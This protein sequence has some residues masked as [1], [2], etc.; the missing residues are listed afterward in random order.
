MKQSFLV[1]I[2]LLASCARSPLKHVEDAMRS[3]SVPKNFQDS[4]SRESFFLTLKNHLEIIKKS[5][6][7]KDPMVFGKKSVEKNVYIESLEKLLQHDQ[8]PEWLNYIKD[9]FDFYEVYGKNE[10]GQVLTTGYY[11]PSARGSLVPTNE[12]SQALYAAPNDL[13]SIDLKKFGSRFYNGEKLELL[14]GRIENQTI[15]PYFSRK[16][17]DGDQKLKGKNLELV[18][19]DPIDAFFIQIQGSGWVLL[20]DGNKIHLGYANQ[21]GQPYFAIGKLIAKNADEMSKMSMQKIR[22]HLKNLPRNNQQDLFNKNPSYVFFKKLEGKALT[23]SGL[24]VSQGRT[25]ATDLRFFPKGAI[26]FLDVDEPHFKNEISEEVDSW[27][28][29]PRLVFDQDTGG[30]IRGGGRVDLYFGEDEKAAQYAGV[31]RQMSKLYYLVPHR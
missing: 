26:A 1:A 9:H 19:L 22:A 17:I 8:D 6:L 7:V 21:N 4:L 24:E 31:M 11:E 2:I 3:A 20:P 13:V 23:Y 5:K 15:I 30:A 12:F 10:W 25:S 27:E 18:W 28:N 14:Q 29:K 16:E